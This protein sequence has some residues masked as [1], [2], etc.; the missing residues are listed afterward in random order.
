MPLKKAGIH[1]GNTTASFSSFLASSK[2]AMLS[3]KRTNGSV[4]Q[5][6]RARL[7]PAPGT[8]PQ[9]NGRTRFLL[10]V[11]PPTAQLALLRVDEHV[12]FHIGIL[13]NDVS[14]Q[15]FHEIFIVACP[16]VFLQFFLLG[17][18]FALEGKQGSVPSWILHKHNLTSQST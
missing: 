7:S 12:P 13:G 17:V 4:D 6:K 9:E 5:F 16:V 8:G 11:A 3:L 1:M 18:S 10:Q 15:S 2:S 14:L